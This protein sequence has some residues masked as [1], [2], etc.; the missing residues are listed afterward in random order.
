MLAVLSTE[1]AS[2]ALAAL[3]EGVICDMK[4]VRMMVWQF[5]AFWGGPI[6]R[7]KITILF[8]EF[9]NQMYL[10]SERTDQPIIRRVS[11]LRIE[12]CLRIVSRAHEVS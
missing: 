4:A 12:S 11:K 9:Y 10:L 2:G 5:K 7:M 6:M 1:Q 3:V 8:L